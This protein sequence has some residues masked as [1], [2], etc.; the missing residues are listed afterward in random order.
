[1]KPV[2]HPCFQCGRPV[3]AVGSMSVLHHHCSR[4]YLS[5]GSSWAWPD[6]QT[7]TGQSSD[8]GRWLLAG[9][10]AW[11]EEIKKNTGLIFK[12]VG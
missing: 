10:V 7:A 3:E 9:A 6:S 8:T 12:S 1:M 5:V 2:S 11:G 4:L